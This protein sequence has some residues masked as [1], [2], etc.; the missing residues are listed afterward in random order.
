MLNE[1]HLEVVFYPD[2]FV[3]VSD[4][5]DIMVIQDF[6]F[7]IVSRK[8]FSTFD[9]EAI[10]VTAVWGN[11]VMLRNIHMWKIFSMR[12]FLRKVEDVQKSGRWFARITAI[13]SKLRKFQQKNPV[14]DMLESMPCH[15]LMDFFLPLFCIKEATALLDMRSFQT[16]EILMVSPCVSKN[17]DMR[18]QHGDFFLFRVVAN[19]NLDLPLPMVNSSKF[20]QVFRCFHLLLPGFGM[21]TMIFW[22]IVFVVAPFLVAPLGF[23]HRTYQQLFP[24]HLSHARFALR[25]DL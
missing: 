9:A 23:F 14:K 12:G 8:P 11:V 21:G 2:E 6:V 19:I 3:S 25:R 5:V 10:G 1:T 22:F 13:G 18:H 16:S 24:Q 4:V 15:G 7:E 17:P 20:V